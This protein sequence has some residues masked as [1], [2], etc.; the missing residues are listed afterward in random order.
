MMNGLLVALLSN[1]SVYFIIPLF[2]TKQKIKD[3]LYKTMSEDEVQLKLLKLWDEMKQQNF[4][5]T[6]VGVVINL[7]FSLFAFYFSFS[8]CAVYITWQN[9]LLMGWIAAVLIDATLYEIGIEVMIFMFY[10]CRGSPSI[11]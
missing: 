7:L 11:A 8:F 4:M 1:I 9:V 3:N 2:R 6:L 10:S 5:K